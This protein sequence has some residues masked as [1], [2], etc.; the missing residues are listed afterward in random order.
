[1]YIYLIFRVK[2]RNI[3]KLIVIV[4]IERYIANR[5]AIESFLGLYEASSNP[6]YYE[7]YELYLVK[8]LKVAS[9]VLYIVFK[10]SY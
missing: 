9:C 8:D 4:F 1:M 6:Y 7:V 2:S 5:T 3:R 10:S